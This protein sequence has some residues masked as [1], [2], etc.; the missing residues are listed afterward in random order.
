LEEPPQ[1][2][3][4]L[5]TAENSESLLPTIVSRCEVL[6]LRAM[7]PKALARVLVECEQCDPIVAA[8]IARLAAG[9]P[10]EALRLLHEPERRIALLHTVEEHLHL[11]QSSML[12]RFALAE[13]LSRTLSKAEIVLLLEHWIT[14]WR[15]VL[16][17]VYQDQEELTYSEFR[18][19][20][21]EIAA[22]TGE[23]RVLQVLHDLRQVLEATQSNVNLR[24]AFEVLF[25]NLPHISLDRSPES[26][27]REATQR[28]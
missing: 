5:L 24:L 20:I 27:V 12:N 2:V 13:R 23:K 25:L 19:Q 22:Q 9:R 18:P 10:G 15:D 11:L 1:R 26:A 8:Q 21:V 14:F 17:S 3:I 28:E 4:L 16:L 7:P 6:H